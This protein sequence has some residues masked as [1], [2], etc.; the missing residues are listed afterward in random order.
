M[1]KENK[2]P[3]KRGNPNWS[4]QP[5]QKTNL[6]DLQRA[7]KLHRALAA[8]GK[9]LQYN[10]QQ[11]S[12]ALASLRT[13]SQGWKGLSQ[14]C[15]DQVIDWYCENCHRS[16]VPSIWNAKALLDRFGWLLD[17]IRAEGPIASPI[18]KDAKQAFA[19][20]EEHLSNRHLP[21]PPAK[22]VLKL[23][24]LTL[25]FYTPFYKVVIPLLQK[26]Q[27]D[28]FRRRF[29]EELLKDWFYEPEAFTEEWIL[30]IYYR[31]MDWPKWHGDWTKDY[32]HLDNKLFQR[33]IRK[34][35]NQLEDEE[36]WDELQA[37]V[38][39]KLK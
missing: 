15:I 33:E 9:S 28:S 38:R 8:Q 20:L 17:C 6:V 34:W 7:K 36:L 14:E 27:P 3:R 19:F 31:A 4:K 29:C 2:T 25:D 5:V 39:E 21:Q 32:W 23:A 10:D 13:P 24:Q 26:K 12:A 30:R 22:P 1:F 35:S 11:W 16:D 37:K 18:S